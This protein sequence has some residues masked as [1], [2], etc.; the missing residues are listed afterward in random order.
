MVGGIQDDW[1]NA[2]WLEEYRMVE[3]IQDGLR[4]NRM[5]WRNTNFQVMVYYTYRITD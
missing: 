5:I 3:G 2:G 1:R 4:E